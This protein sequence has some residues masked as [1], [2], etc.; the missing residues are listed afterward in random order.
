MIGPFPPPPMGPSIRN[1]LI[2]FGLKDSGC[3][4]DNIDTAGPIIKIIFYLPIKIFSSDFIFVSVSKNGQ[5]FLHPIVLIL[6]LSIIRNKNVF[7]YPAG[8]MFYENIMALRPSLRRFY[9]HLL[10]KAKHIFV[11][12]E[13]MKIK[14]EQII[15]KQMV[16]VLPNP[17]P[18][19]AKS[20]I[21][22]S[23]FLPIENRK[24]IFLSRVRKEKGIELLADALFLAET[25]LASKIRVDVYGLVT[26]D[27][28]DRFEEILGA[29]SNIKYMGVL[30]STQELVDRISQYYAMIFPTMWDNEGFPGVLADSALAGLPVV[31]SDIAYNQEII[32]PGERGMMFE[33]GNFESLA[34]SICDIM[35][36]TNLR[37]ALA[38]NAFEY[39]VNYSMENAVRIISEK[40]S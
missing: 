3:A 31:G 21:M 15:D 18:Y 17:K 6:S 33:C 35:R 28:K 34:D 9:I 38:S 39:S 27:Y 30:P 40:M 37:N 19:R 22:Y 26:T 29:N 14:L 10:K 8:G 7:F 20:F 32:A 24:L 13:G 11:Q 25:K 36:D 16:S 2:F 12:T 23:R 1:K 5:I 4:I